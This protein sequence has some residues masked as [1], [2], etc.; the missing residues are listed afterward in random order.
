MRGNST[1]K[2]PNQYSH[3]TITAAKRDLISSAQSS[4]YSSFVGCEQSTKSV[5]EIE[6]AQLF[7]QPYQIVKH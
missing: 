1:K 2:A 5:R 4:K 6:P 7:E 3:S